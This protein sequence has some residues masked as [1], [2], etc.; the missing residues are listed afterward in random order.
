MYKYCEIDCWRAQGVLHNRDP[1]PL[2]QRLVLYHALLETGPHG[3]G[4][5]SVLTATLHHLH[6]TRAPP[7]VRSAAALDSHRST[8]PAV[9]CVCEGSRL[10]TPYEN[11][12]FHGPPWSVEKLS[13]TKL[14]PG[15]KKVGDRCYTGCWGYVHESHRWG[16]G[17]RPCQPASLW[18]QLS[19]IHILRQWGES[20]I[21]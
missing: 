10:C 4:A 3:S 20:R 16:W 8:N 17:Q 13:S 14:V 21:I 11:H 18:I 2:G 12:D 9:N 19:C 6:Y 7:R 15:A 5:S 1:Q